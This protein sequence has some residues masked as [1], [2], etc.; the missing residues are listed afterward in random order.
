MHQARQNLVSRKI[1]REFKT[2]C[3]DVMKTLGEKLDERKD[4]IPDELEVIATS[5]IEDVRAL[6]ACLINNLLENDAEGTQV[7]CRKEILH[8]QIRE[9]LLELES[10]WR[11]HSQNGDHILL[12]DL[13]V[14]KD[15]ADVLVKQEDQERQM[16]DWNEELAELSE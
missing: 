8:Q 12:Q 9:V 5:V 13:S 7:Q 4:T 3:V 10:Q 14:P 6:V 2:M 11:F 16:F 15:L 1:N